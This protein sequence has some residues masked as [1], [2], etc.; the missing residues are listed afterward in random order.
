VVISRKDFELLERFDADGGIALSI[1]L[2]V[3]TP[4]LREGALQRIRARIGSLG[5]ADGADR[6]Q[7]ISEDLDMVELYLGTSA[8]RSLRRVAI[9]S[10]ANQLFWRA[11]P[12]SDLPE[13]YVAVGSRFDVAPLRRQASAR[14]AADRVP[15]LVPD[16]LPQG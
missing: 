8:A 2:D 12:L 5:D 13:E 11:Y 4:A 1:Y 10:C 16:L 7:T 15:T 9:F 3:S 14:T 6:L